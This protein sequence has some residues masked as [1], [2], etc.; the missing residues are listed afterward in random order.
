M[1]QGIGRATLKGVLTEMY[2]DFGMPKHIE[3]IWNGAHE[4]V[5]DWLKA[6]F[7]PVSKL[8]L[9]VRKYSDADDWEAH[10]YRLNV[11]AVFNYFFGERSQS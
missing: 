8:P 3:Y 6:H 7:E 10:I 11:G 2:H 4:Y 5:M 9:A 1:H